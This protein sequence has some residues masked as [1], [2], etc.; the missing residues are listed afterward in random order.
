MENPKTIELFVDTC[1]LKNES[2]R[3]R[4]G[5]SWTYKKVMG[6]QPLN[7]IWNGLP[8]LTIL[9]NGSNHAL[10]EDTVENKI[11]TIVRIIRKRYSLKIPI[12]IKMDTGFL[13]QNLFKT[14]DE[15]N[16]NFISVCR[17]D[18]NTK[19]NAE[20]ISKTLDLKEYSNK[21]NDYEYCEFGY[22]YKSWEKYYRVIYLEIKNNKDQFSLKGFRE[23]TLLITNLKQDFNKKYSEE[24]LEYFKAEKIIELNHLRGNDELTHRGIKDFGTEKLP[25]QKF[26]QNAAFY[27]TMIISYFL[28]EC[29]KKDILYPTKLIKLNSYATTIRRKIIDVAGKII[30]TSGKIILKITKNAYDFLNPE[31]ILFQIT[32]SVRII[33]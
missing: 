29:F 7:I 1:V 22:K 10:S 12:I 25:L 8:I 2:C 19:I 16:V 33:V 31:K 6:Y 5:V 11:K 17:W 28:F 20:N 4:E 26:N 18:V 24:L 15:L 30:K 21:N 27:Y 3:K 14:L 32:K 9:K 23:K 13:C